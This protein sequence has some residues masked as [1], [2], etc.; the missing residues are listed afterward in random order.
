MSNKLSNRLSAQDAGFLYLERQDVPLHIGSLGVYEGRISFERFSNH[1][2]SRMPLIPRYRQ[3][4]TFVPLSIAHPAWEDDP[5]F[6][7]ENHV[8]HVPLPAPGTDQQLADLAAELFAQPL[9]RGKPLWEMYVIDGIE[10]DRTGILSKVHHCMVDGV[11]GIALLMATVDINPEP[12][13]A[14]ETAPWEPGPLPDVGARLAD[15][16]WDQLSEQRDILQEFQESLIDP[17]PRL[18]RTQDILRAMN[19]ASPSDGLPAPRNP[20]ATTLGPERRVAFTE[21]SFV[22]IREIRK[23]LGGTVNDVVLAILAGALRRYLTADDQNA[24]LPELRTAIPVNIRLEGEE[25][26]L[27]NRISCMLTS[28][29]I[30]EA[31]PAQRLATIHDRL[32]LLK[33]EN[34]AGGLELLARTANY[35]PVPIQ[36][37]AGLAPSTSTLVDLICTNVPGPMIPLYSV[38][39]LMLAHYPMV[40]LSFDLGLSVGVT[41]YNQRL[42]FGLMTEPSAVPDVDLLKQ[43]VDESFLELRDAAGVGPSDVPALEAQHNGQKAARPKKSAKTSPTSPRSGARRP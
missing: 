14:P 38:G 34:Q 7:I 15:A 6:R 3:R 5:D 9:D 25:E 19:L 12:A 4:L 16:F 28:L 1:I 42:Y 29:P 17:A 35:V 2:N 18:R 10:G 39:H 40:P 33:Q 22:E 13:P 21:M 26:S 41:S 31:D 8:Y 11:S 32:D 23:S 20:F 36:A 30:G 43:Y 24:E 37:L 27:G